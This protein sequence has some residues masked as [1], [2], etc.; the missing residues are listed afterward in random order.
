MDNNNE[1]KDNVE[2]VCISLDKPIDPSI[3][4]K[5]QNEITTIR[6]AMKEEYK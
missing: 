6:K 1:N 5:M 4:D 3:R 2:Q